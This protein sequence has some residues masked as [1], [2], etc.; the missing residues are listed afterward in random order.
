MDGIIRLNIILDHRYT[1][2]PAPQL[3][4][5]M[6]DARA[7]LWL[8][9]GGP[10]TCGLKFQAATWYFTQQPRKDPDAALEKKGATATCMGALHPVAR[11]GRS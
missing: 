4:A 1:P 5:H 8:D 11:G 3:G 2:S 9:Q 6:R 10:G 7:T